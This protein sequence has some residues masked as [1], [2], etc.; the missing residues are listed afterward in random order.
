MPLYEY[1]CRACQHS[2]EEI[3]SFSDKPLEVCPHCKK[4]E[5]FRVVSGGLG[6][7]TSNRTL[8]ATADNNADKYSSDFKEHLNIKNKTKQSDDLKLKDGASIME[9]PK[10]EAKKPWY[11]KNQTVTDKKLKAATPTQLQNYIEKGTL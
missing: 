4:T 1:E 2:L 5:L 7:Y 10:K 11:K 9:K 6:F 8:G 3:Q